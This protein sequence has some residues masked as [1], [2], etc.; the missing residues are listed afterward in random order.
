M[1]QISDLFAEAER[2]NTVDKADYEAELSELRMELLNLQYDLNR[3]DFSVVLLIVG[4]DLPGVVASLRVL[5]E[6]MD[7]RYIQN[8][9]MFDTPGEKFAERPLVKRYWQRLPPSGSIGLFLGAWPYLLLGTAFD[10]DWSDEELDRGL[11][12]VSRFEKLLVDDGT[13]LLKYWLHL[14][15][16][17]LKNRVAAAER[18][19]QKYWD[20][21]QY[22]WK[23]LKRYDDR[24]DLVERLM[25][26]T[27]TPS[28]P[29]RIIESADPRYRNLA[30]GNHIAS[31]LQKR[32]YS[33][34]AQTVAS[35][36]VSKIAQS[37]ESAMDDI[38]LGASVDEDTYRKKLPKLQARLNRLSHRAHKAGV[39]CVF[40]F[41]GVDAAGKGGAI[42]RL[43]SALPVQHTRVIPIA[44]PSETELARHYLWRFWTRLP[45][46]G[47]TVIFDRSWY[48]RVLVE[49]VEELAQVHEWSR[50]YEEINEFEASLH[51][52]NF[53]VCK[54]WLQI[55]TDTQLSRFEA[56]AQT[57][58]KKYKLTDQDYRNREKWAQHQAAAEEMIALTSTSHAP[59][60]LV[61]ANDKRHARLQVLSTVVERLDAQLRILDAADSKQHRKGK[62]K[63]SG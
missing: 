45:D 17:K 4:D 1:N 5:H 8:H 57:P 14:P 29:W 20:Y 60:T 9:V 27:N 11:D 2:G 62:K 30:L 39:H 40:L 61:A 53:V 16:K 19:P 49:R 28:T 52:S 35:N 31:A 50:A 33:D 56:R 37:D 18:N 54:F 43:A 38:D 24:F 55:D 47:K 26:R 7:G 25:G 32:L 3:R 63:R 34:S 15:K 51:D 42:R 41:E 12:D 59:W 6:W 58:Y 36:A 21:A 46:A 44:A 10:E 22:D 13:L 23:F 48:G